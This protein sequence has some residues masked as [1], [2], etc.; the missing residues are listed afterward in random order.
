MCQ[1]DGCRN[2]IRQQPYGPTPK[3]CS[4]ACRQ[5][6]Y[7]DRKKIPRMTRGTVPQTWR[8]VPLPS[9]DD[10]KADDDAEDWNGEPDTAARSA[11][12]PDDSDDEFNDQPRT[13]LADTALALAGLLFTPVRPRPPRARETVV[14]SELVRLPARAQLTRQTDPRPAAR[15]LDDA[16]VIEIYGVSLTSQTP[17][18]GRSCQACHVRT[19]RTQCEDAICRLVI[20]NPQEFGLPPMFDACRRCAAQL[21]QIGRIVEPPALLARHPA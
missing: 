3:Y 8:S 14:R 4:D 16:D 12:L 19:G 11:L 10:D 13:T 17:P 20:S 15:Q 5:A 18:I 1:R 21:H 9:E 7:R 2:E 6:A